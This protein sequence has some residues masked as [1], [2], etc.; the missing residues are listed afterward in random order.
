MIVAVPELM[1]A[2][3]ALPPDTV[4]PVRVLLLTVIVPPYP[5]LMPAGCGTGEHA[6]FFAARGHAVTGF[7]FLEEPI[8][9]A[10]SKA[11][12][13][14]LIVKFMVRDALK[15]HE[16]TERFDNVIDS[17][18]FHVFSDTDRIRYVRGLENVLP[19]R[20]CSCFVSVTP[21][22]EWKDRDASRS[23]SCVMPLP[24]AGKSNPSSPCASKSVLS[25][26]NREPSSAKTHAAGFSSPAAWLK[27]ASSGAY[28]S[29]SFVPPVL[30]DSGTHF[31]FGVVSPDGVGDLLSPPFR[32]SV[33]SESRC[34]LPS[35]R[36]TGNRSPDGVTPT[37]LLRTRSYS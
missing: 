36:V 16:W 37:V 4:L 31:G 20:V 6:L 35:T 10:R 7:D 14:S 17:G 21:L 13:R 29:P 23:P 8:A 33:F 11:V 27:P 19:A 24:M 18:L 32:L 5:L 15:L 1:P 9:A 2:P 28:L 30:E 25:T 22:R 26:D 34:S 12:E 3:R